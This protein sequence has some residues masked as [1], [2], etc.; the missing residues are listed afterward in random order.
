MPSPHPPGF[1]T[2]KQLYRRLRETDTDRVSVDDTEVPQWQRQTVW[3][4]DDQGLLALSVLQ[5]YPIGVMVLWRNQ[6]GVL[7]PIDGRQRI[8]ALNNF[9]NGDVS[10]PNQPWIDEHYRSR[11]FLMKEGDVESGFRPLSTEEIER[12]ED[13][14]L[15]MLQYDD[16]PEP[17]AMD[18]FVRLQ[19]G[20]SLTK[21][22]VRAALGGRVCDYVT[23]LTS[24]AVI[25]SDEDEDAEEPVRH[26]FFQL[27]AGNLRN[28]RKAH[29]N[30][31]DLLLHEHL[32]PSGDKHWSSLEAMYRE[33]ART[34]TKADQDSF[35]D[36][37]SKFQRALSSGTGAEAVLAPPLRGALFHSERVSMVAR[38]LAELFDPKRI[39]F[40]R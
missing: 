33:K 26:R 7:V 8:T 11:K 36:A 27:L 29:R 31:C 35:R 40:R 5:G 3:N 38:T 34:L 18:V 14:E 4:S 37:L 10:I 13:Y 28:S 19:N 2:V 23:E 6:R 32:Y 9:M 30:V 39:Q 21:T 25:R 24:P 17:F 20:K 22:E 16:T 1:R 12:F 15:L